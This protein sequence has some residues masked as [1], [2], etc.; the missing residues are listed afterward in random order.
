ML[1]CLQR[2]RPA[3]PRYLL[4]DLPPPADEPIATVAADDNEQTA[5][6]QAGTSAQDD[7]LSPDQI[8]PAMKELGDSVTSAA[9][10][11]LEDDDPPDSADGAGPSSGRTTAAAVVAATGGGG[12]QRVLAARQALLAE[13]QASAPV[14]GRDQANT[15]NASLVSRHGGW[16]VGGTADAATAEQPLHNK[17]P[18]PFDNDTSNGS[19]DQQSNTT[20]EFSAPQADAVVPGNSVSPVT[21]L[22]AGMA[23]GVADGGV[24]QQEEPLTPPRSSPQSWPLRSLQP[25]P[26]HHEA[27]GSPANKAPVLV[28]PMVPSAVSNGHFIDQK[29]PCVEGIGIVSSKVSKSPFVRSYDFSQLASEFPG[30]DTISCALDPGTA[31]SSGPAGSSSTQE[32]HCIGSTQI[33]VTGD[34]HY[35]VLH[36]S[37]DRGFA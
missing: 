12:S 35:V 5:A 15:S 34:G 27:A 29:G 31:A 4:P 14:A 8:R 21:M 9:R 28:S 16:V 24:V 17:L 37:S 11:E 19:L 7:G 3:K 20:R 10:F 13:R 22:I 26:D 2:R 36:G 18:T 30:T 1:I 32:L 23:S 6:D 33:S 25:S